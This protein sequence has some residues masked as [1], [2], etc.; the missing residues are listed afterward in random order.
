MDRHT[1]LIGEI[2]NAHKIS[3]GEHTNCIHESVKWIQMTQDKDQGYTS[4]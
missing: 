3:T 1:T 4:D 2:R